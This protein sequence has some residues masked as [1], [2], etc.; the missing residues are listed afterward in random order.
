MLQSSRYYSYDWQSLQ[1]SSRTDTTFL[2]V[3]KSFDKVLHDGL[4][5]KMDQMRYPKNITQIIAS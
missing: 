3:T 1:K 2:D 5:H 4:M